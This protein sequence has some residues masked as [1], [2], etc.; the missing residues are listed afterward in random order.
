MVINVFNLLHITK[1]VNCFLQKRDTHFV[2]S[3]KNTGKLYIRGQKLDLCVKNTGK[4][5]HG[6]KLD[7][8]KTDTLCKNTGKLYHGTKLDTEKYVFHTVNK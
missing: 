4:L 5:H 6:T 1:F 2:Y 3:K 8:G 7:T